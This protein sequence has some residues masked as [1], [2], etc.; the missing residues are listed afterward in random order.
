MKPEELIIRNFENE[1]V[2]SSS[3]SSGPGGQNINKLNTKVELRFNINKTSLL[4]D[5]EKEMLCRK[6][7]NKINGEG[8]LILIAQ[9]ERTQLMNKKIV[10]EKF[11]FLVSKALTS[12]QKR[13]STRPTTASKIKRLEKKKKHGHIKKLRNQAEELSN[14]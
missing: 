1:F 8:E 13:R 7:P 11:Y 5:E 2:Y 3:R 10:T 12:P 4:S 14:S 6:L 9:S